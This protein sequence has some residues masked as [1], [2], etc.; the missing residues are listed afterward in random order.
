MKLIITFS[1]FLFAIID[2]CKPANEWLGT[3]Y[4][5]DQLVGVCEVIVNGNGGYK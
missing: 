2:A 4:V 5:N 1:I 3:V